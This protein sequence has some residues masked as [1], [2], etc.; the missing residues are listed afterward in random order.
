MSLSAK[1]QARYSASRVAALTNPDQPASTST[2]DTTRLD[3]ASEDAAA[4]FLAVCGVAYDDTDTRH[5]AVA[6]LAVEWKLLAYQGQ[7]TEVAEKAAEAFL[8]AAERYALTG[9]GRARQGP[10]TT[11]VLTPSSEVTGARP[12]MDRENLSGIQLRA[13]RTGGRL[14]NPRPEA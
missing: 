2:A 13:P 4:E 10:V 8:A 6:V 7:H 11:S 5:V 9:G 14:T 3:A 12:D 1:F